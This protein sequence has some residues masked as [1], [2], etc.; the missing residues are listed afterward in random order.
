MKNRYRPYGYGMKQ[1]KTVI[2]LPE[3]EV[4]QRIFREYLSGA[5]LKVIAENL[6][7]EQIPFLPGKWEWN[8]NRID[9]ILC[10]R[11]YL[12]TEDYEPIIDAETFRQAREIKL[13]RNTQ[14]AYDKEKVISPAV[15]PILCGKCGQPTKRRHDRRS[16]FLQKHTCENPDCKA[17]YRINDEKMIALISELLNQTEPTLPKA[18]QQDA[19]LEIRRME[20]EIAR[21]LERPDTDADTLKELILECAA[22]KY[23]AVSSGQSIYDKLRT[24][25]D[26]TKPSSLYTRK[27]VMETVKEIVLIDDDTIQITL[28][29][30]QKLRKEQINGTGHDSTG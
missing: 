5:S 3:S 25:L 27:A 8:K 21:M 24:D 10:D 15:V 4:V 30:G 23:Q 19:A 16:S 7:A 6:T 22:M 26:K 28:P 12:G 1:G 17:E 11:R 20:N 13:E 29:N 9:R 18:E 2:I 14:T